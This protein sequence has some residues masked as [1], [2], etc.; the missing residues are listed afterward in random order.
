MLRGNTRT[1]ACAAVWLCLLVVLCGGC[2]ESRKPDSTSGGS[3][4]AGGGLGPFGNPDGGGATFTNDGAVCAPDDDTCIDETPSGGPDGGTHHPGDSAVTDPHDD[5]GTPDA[6]H[7]DPDGATDPDPEPDAAE[8]EPDAEI[9]DPE[10]GSTP[11]AATYKI[12]LLFVIDNSNSMLAEQAA[13]RAQFPML[14]SLLLNSTAIGGGEDVV[15]GAQDIHLGVVSSD[16]GAPGVLDIAGCSGTGDD[17]VLRNTAAADAVGCSETIYTPRFLSYVAGTDDPAQTATDLSCI[18]ALGNDGCGFEMQL[19]SM[20]KAVWPGDDG[21][22]AFLGDP[23]GF[24]TTGQAGTAFPNGDFVRPSDDDDVSVLA[25]VM[26][27]DEE[28]CSSNDTAHLVPSFSQMGL[29]TRCYYEGLAPEPNRL[30]DVSRYVSALRNLRPGYEQ[31][32]VFGA[33]VGVP[34][35]LVT[36]AALSAVDFSNSAERNAHYDAV[37]NH[38]LMQEAVDDR[39]NVDPADDTMVPSC[40]TTS[41]SALAYPPRRIVEV[42]RGFGEHGFVQSICEED[43]SY[44]I[45]LLATRIAQA[46]S[47]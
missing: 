25:V 14:I 32:V 34:T 46:R 44:A 31:R 19:E 23:S 36:E 17:G 27:T 33:I 47:E 18:A 29:N 20:L 1:S 40:T 22:V 4:G 24:G 38:P 11:T 28:D 43:W 35:A 12:D 16:L 39:G 42:A 26:V 5:G 10:D 8:P 41:G 21:R 2:S 6:A 15:A 7:L 30:F 45:E 9:I 37:L 13:L 3:G